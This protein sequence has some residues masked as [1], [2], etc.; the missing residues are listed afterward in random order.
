MEDKLFK[1]LT[2]L[3]AGKPDAKSADIFKS[4]LKLSFEGSP[5]VRRVARDLLRSH[6]GTDVSD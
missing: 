1:I 2:L 6:F 3:N 4:L 5:A